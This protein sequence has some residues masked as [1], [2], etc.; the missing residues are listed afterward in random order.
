MPTIQVQNLNEVLGK[1]NMIRAGYNERDVAKVILEEGGK[2]L[3]DHLRAAAP[4]GPTGNL[5]KAIQATIA[6]A[7][8]LSPAVYVSVRRSIAHHLHLVTGGTKPHR[9]LAKLAHSLHIGG[10]YYKFV[11]HPGA[12]PNDY[13][14]NTWEAYQNETSESITQGLGKLFDKAAR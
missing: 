5:R 9:I 8:A 1:M 6:R 13:F 11:D 3:R 10:H 4:L 7:K 12:K 2:P 14:R